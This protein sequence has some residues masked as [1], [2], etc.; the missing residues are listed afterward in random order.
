MPIALIPAG[1]TPDISANWGFHALAAN[2]NNYSEAIADVTTAG[3]NTTLTAA[4]AL[5]GFTRLNA[6]ASGGFTITLPSTAAILATLGP[7]IP[8]DGSYSEPIHMLNN[9]VGQTGTL[10]IGDSSTTLSGTMTVAT[11][12][13]R[14]FMLRVTSASTISIT[15]VGSWGL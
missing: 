13:V 10:T 14:K 5:V 11:S 3:T 15:N 4:Q 2:I 7:T 8:T 9:A 12:T 1:I 6:G